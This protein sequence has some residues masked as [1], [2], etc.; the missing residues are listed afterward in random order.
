[1]IYVRLDGGVGNQMFQYA[2]GRSLALR[3]NTNVVLDVSYIQDA[4]RKV[5]AR[6]YGLDAF[7]IDA[8]LCSAK[9]LSI[10]KRLARFPRFFHWMSN[11]KIYC[12][13]DRGFNREFLLLPDNVYLCGYWQSYK[14]F[15]SIGDKLVN[16]FSVIQKHCQHGE[17]ILREI[18][19]SNSVAVHI[20]RGDYLSLAAAA[21]FHG[22]LPIEYYKTAIKKI[23][24]TQRNL[25]FFIFSDDIRWSKENVSSIGGPLTFVGLEEKLQPW[26]DL[27]L[28]K[29][30][31]HN[32]LANSSFSWWS[33]WL[34]MQ[35][36]PKHEKVIIAPKQW[37]AGKKVEETT[38]RFPE[39][40]IL[41]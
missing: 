19:S 23:Q 36:A 22:I 12:E 13:K 31:Q 30:C 7:Q 27:D 33:A 3:H 37:F 9:E 35:V 20:R 40:W 10:E 34:G 17:K 5:T 21:K 6:Q 16:E 24:Q 8:K 28:M 1:M 2:A 26:Q 4:S 41:L 18:R 32:I 29:S 15:T 11:R 38:D 39:G 25:H 14:Y